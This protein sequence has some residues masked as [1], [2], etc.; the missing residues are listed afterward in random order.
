MLDVLIYMSGVLIFAKSIVGLY[1]HFTNNASRKYLDSVNDEVKRIYSIN[2]KVIHPESEEEERI[3]TMNAFELERYIAKVYADHGM[4]KQ[5]RLHILNAKSIA[6]D[7]RKSYNSKK[8]DPFTGQEIGEELIW[9]K[10]EVLKATAA[11]KQKAK[12]EEAWKREQEE[13]YQSQE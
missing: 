7:M 8:D 9:G 3:V 11:L 13:T 5:S 12:A 4:Y 1:N 10:D 2:N 6:K